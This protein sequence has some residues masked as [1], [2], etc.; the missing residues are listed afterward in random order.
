MPNGFSMMTREFSASLVWPSMAT[1]E[2]NA[3]GG[4]A[5][6]KSRLGWPPIACSASCTAFSSGLGSSGSAAP[7]LSLLTKSSHAAPVGLARPNSATAFLACAR[8]SSSL[9]ANLA[10]AEPTIR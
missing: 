4:T 3:D 10:G 2:P 8:N 1:T 7:K 6:W 9:I 5:R